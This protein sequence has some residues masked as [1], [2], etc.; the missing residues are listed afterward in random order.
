MP[1]RLMSKGAASS[2]DRRLATGQPGEDCP[3]GRIGE[4]GECRA[5]GV[6]VHVQVQVQVH[7][8]IRLINLSA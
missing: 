3:A 2:D 4:G 6:G 1:G 5:E 7:F 8:A